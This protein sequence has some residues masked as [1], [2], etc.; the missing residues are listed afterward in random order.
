MNDGTYML[1]FARNFD[2]NHVYYSLLKTWM[3]GFYTVW[4]T[5]KRA[6][7]GK[8]STVQPFLANHSS[9]LFRSLKQEEKRHAHH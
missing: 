5:G 1:C 4:H 6:Y 9:L 8:I 2:D 7:F 3:H